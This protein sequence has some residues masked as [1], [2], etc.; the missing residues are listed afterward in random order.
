MSLDVSGSKYVRVYDPAIR[1]NYSDKVVFANLV[2]SRKTGNVKVDKSTGEVVMN[3]DTG[4]EVP[5]RAYSRWEG[6]FVGNAFEPSKGLRDGTAI[7]IITGWVTYEPF[8]GR[9]NKDHVK[10][11]VT[12]SDFTPSE[13]AEGEDA[14]PAEEE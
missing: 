2:T 12:I 9:D 1:L 5:E 7:D 11:I 3:P 13:V 6:R 8:K 14:N 4:K 10:A